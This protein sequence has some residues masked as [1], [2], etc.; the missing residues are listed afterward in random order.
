MENNTNRGLKGILFVILALLALLV[1][2]YIIKNFIP[3]RTN[4]DTLPDS[5]NKIDS[6]YISKPDSLPT[7]QITISQKNGIPSLLIWNSKYVEDHKMNKGSSLTREWIVLNDSEC[8][9]QLTNSVGINTVIKDSDLR[10]TLTGNIN[11]SQPITAYQIFHV[12][13][14]VFGEHIKTL[15]NLGIEDINGTKSFKNKDSWYATYNQGSEYVRC[16]SFV[17]KVRTKEGIIWN[18]DPNAI[19]NELKKIEIIYKEEYNP[20]NENEE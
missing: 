8:P 18:Y 13:Y 12:L 1:V 5:K 2:M 11:T 3:K 17:R 15:S 4:I 10:F 7:A 9:V 6:T 16:V 14:D 20:S 19:N